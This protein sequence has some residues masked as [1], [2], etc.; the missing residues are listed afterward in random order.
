[1][2]FLG[3]WCRFRWKRI[4]IGQR[5][6][7]VMFLLILVGLTPYQVLSYLHLQSLMLNHQSALL[8]ERLQTALLL[9]NHDAKQLWHTF[10]D[11][12]F[13]GEARLAVERRDLE[14]LRSNILDWIPKNFNI[15]VVVILDTQGRVIGGNRKQIEPLMSASQP[16]VERAKRGVSTVGLARVE[17]RLYHVVCAPFVGE[18]CLPSTGVLVVAKHLSPSYLRSLWGSLSSGLELS[19]SEGGSRVRGQHIAD[20]EEGFSVRYLS[21]TSVQVSIPLLDSESKPIASLQ[22]TTPP[23]QSEQIQRVLWQAKLYLVGSALFITAGVTGVML[24]FLRRQVRHFLY[25][26]NMLASGNWHVRVA[27]PAKDEFGE[28]ARAFNQMADQLQTAF[29]TQLAHQREILRQKEE[30][31]KLYHQLQLVNSE[32]ERLNQ[33]LQEHNALLAQAV[34][35]DSLTGLKNHRAFH[36]ALIS[37]VQMAERFQQPL[38]LI[39]LDVDYFKQF[40]D[41]YGHPA[42]DEVLKR[43]GEVLRK[44]SRAY[45]VPARY[46]GEEFAVLLPNTGLQEA[47]QIAERLRRQI[48]SL[49]NPYRPLTASFGVAEYRHGTMPA[50]LLYEADSALY[51]AK[52]AGRNC[53]R[54]YQA[55]LEESA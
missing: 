23:A 13:R 4:P 10:E 20:S 24:Y 2:G 29:E 42:G 40:N 19:L 53:V 31:E 8:Q 27:Y 5:F 9:L 17:G 3:W 35:T 44:N 49:E 46:G 16:L 51:Q 33:E 32:L 47:V 7:I 38:S 39:M 11:Y 26:V 37:T 1:M 6:A 52:Q 28:L 54:V 21:P 14:W 41:Q 30:Q 55:E 15:D 48:E 45:D 22:A 50:T 36:E 25:A 12:A 34:M 43:V 18:E